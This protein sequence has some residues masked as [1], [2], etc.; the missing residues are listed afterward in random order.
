MHLSK[1]IINTI[2]LMFFTAVVICVFS[3]CQPTIGTPWYPRSASSSSG[4]FVITG[5]QVKGVP[6]TAV[7]AET[8]TDDADKIK[9]FSE[10]KTYM[11]N[12]PPKIAEITAEDIAITAVSSLSHKKALPVEVT[13]NG[14]SVPL[15]AGQ[16]VP[17]T[18][19][20]ADPSGKSGK[21]NKCNATRTIRIEIKTPY[22]L[23]YRRNDGEY[24]GS[25]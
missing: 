16:V 25:L 21:N 11:V 10:A 23:R 7:L 12:V 4:G 15:S 22:C 8:P 5:I 1:K 13:V 17:I 14:G 20:I 3:A 6:V 19:K 24:Y 2:S 9:K 18:I